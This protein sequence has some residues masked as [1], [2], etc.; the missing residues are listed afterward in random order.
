MRCSQIQLN[1][2]KDHKIKNNLATLLSDIK[3]PNEMREFLES[4]LSE[5]EFIGLS[6]RITII[7]LLAKG[8]SYE[9]IQKDL[10]VSS[11]TVSSAAS[12]E[13][14]KVLA[15]IIQKFEVDDWASNLA[16]KIIKFYPFK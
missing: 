6:K 15:K 12:F 4:F 7:K 1:K 8:F 13:D 11:A 9:Q 14:D 3:N 10:N 5:N 16:K 2:A